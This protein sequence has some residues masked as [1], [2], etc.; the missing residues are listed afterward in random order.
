[1]ASGIDDETWLYHLLRHDYSKWFKYT[2]KDDELALY[3]EKVE[4]REHDP[5]LSRQ[6]IFKSI[7]DRY[8]A[9]A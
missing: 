4:T 1:M 6:A 2:V 8:T 9:S 3:T 5:A 7:L